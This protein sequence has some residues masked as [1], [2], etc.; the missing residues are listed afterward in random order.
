MFIPQIPDNILTDKIKEI[1][2]LAGQ[3]KDIRR[4][5]FN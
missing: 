5:V 4:F 3:L 2:D 1:V